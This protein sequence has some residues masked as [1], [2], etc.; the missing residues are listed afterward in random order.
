LPLSTASRLIQ[1]FAINTEDPFTVNYQQQLEHVIKQ[2]ASNKAIRQM[3]ATQNPL[4]QTEAVS[5]I[6]KQL[7]PAV[8]EQVVRS[9]TVPKTIPKTVSKMTVVD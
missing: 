3:D 8:L 2:A 7:Q 9:T 5:Q 6:V 1:K 4:Q